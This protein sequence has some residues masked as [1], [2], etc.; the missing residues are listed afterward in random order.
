[1]QCIPTT[2]ILKH[3]WLWEFGTVPPTF[4][5]AYLRQPFKQTRKA[6]Q[7]RTKFSCF[8]RTE[9]EKNK[10]E[11]R[12]PTHLRIRLIRIRIVIRATCSK[13]S[14]CCNTAFWLTKKKKW[15]WILKEKIQIITKIQ[16]SKVECKFEKNTAVVRV[17]PFWGFPNTSQKSSVSSSRFKYLWN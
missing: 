2:R 6:E 16:A 10:R 14:S 1:M 4:F 17:S 3:L 12:Q 8:Q 7:N 5:S 11:V 9:K 13:H 15:E